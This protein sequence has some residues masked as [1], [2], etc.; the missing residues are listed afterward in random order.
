M[1]TPRSFDIAPSPPNG[2]SGA[3]RQIDGVTLAAMLAILI[4]WF[5]VDTLVVSVGSL[6]HGVRFFDLSSAIANPMKIFFRVDGS[7]QRVMF[8]AV[9]LACLLAPVLA[10]RRR[11]RWAWAAYLAP[12]ALMLISA[13]LLYSRTSGEFLASSADPNSLRGNVIRFANNLVHGGGVLISRHIS[14]GSGGYL[15]F[16]G[17]V[18][19]A[20][21]GTRHFRRHAA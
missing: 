12:L 5:F 17:S 14:I 1:D 3:P 19:L 16:A 4:G 11:A 6:Q 8:G 10:H 7:F 18:V 13:A 15:A 2:P 21:R 9:C 20:L